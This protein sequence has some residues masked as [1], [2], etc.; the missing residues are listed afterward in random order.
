MQVALIAIVIIL[1]FGAYLMMRKPD[2]PSRKT[3][4]KQAAQSPSYSRYSSVSIMLPKSC[5]GAAQ[6]L[7]GQRLLAH[8]APKLPLASCTMT[9]CKCGYMRHEDRRLDDGD[10]RAI[11]GLRAEMHA[12]QTGEERRK[13]KGRRAGDLALA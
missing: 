7:V 6:E 4:K 2:K 9:P 5:C 13:R 10:R 11:Y 12:L 8:E 1:G 3:P